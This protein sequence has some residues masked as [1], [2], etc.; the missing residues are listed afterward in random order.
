MKKACYKKLFKLLIDVEMKRG[1]LAKLA[2]ISTSTLTKLVKG[3]CVNMDVLVR[4]C[5]ALDC[6]LHEIVE[7]VPD[8]ETDNRR[9][10]QNSNGD[11][12]TAH[13][14]YDER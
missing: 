4:I 9:T 2:K 7:L 10:K 6:D 8:G 1:E 11:K 3:E 12:I 13:D 5:T 14:L